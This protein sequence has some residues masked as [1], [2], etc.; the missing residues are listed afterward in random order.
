MEPLT[1]YERMKR[2]YAH[3]EADRV[4]IID[5]PWGATIERWQSEGMPVDVHFSEYFGFDR[6]EHVPINMG[7]IPG[8]VCPTSRVDVNLDG[9]VDFRDFALM[10]RSWSGDDPA[11]DIIPL[12]RRD[13]KVDAHDLEALGD[14][15]LTD[16]E[17]P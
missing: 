5:S 14:S 10:G 9:K 2:M 4:P 7:L 11:M 17:Q 6:Y 12:E 16:F 15:W 3:Q 1:T 8:M 13:G